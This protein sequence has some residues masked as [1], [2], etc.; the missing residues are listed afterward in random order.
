MR[1]LQP[2]ATELIDLHEE[3]LLDDAT[4]EFFCEATGNE[5]SYEIVSEILESSEIE[6]EEEYYDV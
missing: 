2:F 3:S 6:E 1:E 5:S 4:E